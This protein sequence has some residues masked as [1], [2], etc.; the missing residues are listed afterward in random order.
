MDDQD[1]NAIF[2]TAQDSVN[3]KSSWEK[4]K[5]AVWYSGR[6]FVRNSPRK[7]FQL[8]VGKVTEIIPFLG[9]ALN[10]GSDSLWGKYKDHRR[11]E[12]R[13]LY[14]EDAYSSPEI[15]RKFAKHELKELKHNLIGT[16]DRNL[17]KLKDSVLELSRAETAWN[18][19]PDAEKAYKLAWSALEVQRREQKLDGLLEQ[20]ILALTH[21]QHYIATR[22]ASTLKMIDDIKFD[23]RTINI[24]DDGKAHRTPAPPL[25]PRPGAAKSAA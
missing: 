16:I 24:S 9:D 23:F 12:K 10:E 2:N 17:V 8:T 15:E 4:F 13:K 20:A 5:T 7:V 11:L 19:N 18:S 6:K 3:N 1:I 25:P 21:V 22:Q 14:G